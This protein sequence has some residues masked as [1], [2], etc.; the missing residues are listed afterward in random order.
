MRATTFNRH[1]PTDMG[2]SIERYNY[3]QQQWIQSVMPISL[4]KWLEDNVG[5]YG[6]ERIHSMPELS[7]A[8]PAA[9]EM[10]I[11]WDNKPDVIEVDIPMELTWLPPQFQGRKII[12]IGEARIS[13]MVLRRKQAARRIYGF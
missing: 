2:L 12:F 8:G 5:A 11:F 9:T 6:I 3:L 13:D 7:G 4:L 10:A 1:S